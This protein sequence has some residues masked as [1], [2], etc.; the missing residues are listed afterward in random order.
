MGFLLYAM[1]CYAIGFLCYSFATL[2]C[3]IPMLCYAV[4]VSYSLPCNLGVRCTR[5]FFNDVKLTQV[6]QF[7][8][9]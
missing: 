8:R 2:C 3:T 7:W 4:L 1:L 9:H 5:E 6:A